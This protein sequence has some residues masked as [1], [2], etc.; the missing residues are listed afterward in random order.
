MI[1]LKIVTKTEG[2]DFFD[3]LGDNFEISLRTLTIL[4]NAGRRRSIMTYE[5]R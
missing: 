2:D 3:N 5:K 4:Y 1:Q